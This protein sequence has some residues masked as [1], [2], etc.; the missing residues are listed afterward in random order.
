M[1]LQVNNGPLAGLR[2]IEFAGLGPGPFCAMM[3]A[4]HGAEVIR[5]DRPGPFT[6]VGLVPAPELDFVT[7]SRRSIAID[8]KQPEGVRLA[9][10]LASGADAIIEGFRPGTMERLGLGPEDLFAENARLVYGR[11]TGWGQHG[12][13][14]A[15]AGHDI[16]YIALSGVLNGI[17]RAGEKPVPPMNLIGDYGGG[18]MMLGF[19][20]LAAILH[21]RTTGDGQVV[22]CSMVKG[23]ALLMTAIYSKR[24][25][26]QWS[27]ER[28]VN[29]FDSGAPFYDV[30]ETSDGRHVAVGALEPA[31]FRE[32]VRL[33]A[34]D[35]H[36]A[37]AQQYD[38][39][40]WDAQREA[41]TAVFRSR[42][43]AEW[44]ELLMQTDACYAP[45][46]SMAEATDDPHNRAIETFVDVAGRSQPAPAPTYSRSVLGRPFDMESGTSTT[47]A[48]LSDAGFDP[49]EIAALEARGIVV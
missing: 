32:L 16:N 15:V 24:A 11:M 5:V 48:V 40:S 18:A 43:R 14:A 10:R 17:G 2:V 29:L 39:E 37:F 47:H 20:M 30:Y 7:R 22:D 42:T 33:L 4:D 26:D 35:R 19:G 46:L 9:R 1:T 12:P 41:L 3:L 45:V 27:D 13:Y 34:L 49:V 8:L 44:D 23:S 28:G 25:A 36:P 31:F 6:S 38:K 21:A